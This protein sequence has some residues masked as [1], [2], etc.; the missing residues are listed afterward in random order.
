MS[1]KFN[2]SSQPD[3][4]SVSDVNIECTKSNLIDKSGQNRSRECDF[5]S[6]AGK[7][8]EDTY[9]DISLL[10]F[11]DLEVKYILVNAEKVISE[12]E[13]FSNISVLHTD[14]IPGKYEGGLKIWECS[15]DLAT[16]LVENSS[17]I[18][19]YTVLELGCGAGLPGIVAY[20]HGASVTFQDFN[21]EV[22]EYSTLPNTVLNTERS[23]LSKIAEMCSYLHGDWEDIMKKYYSD[24]T[25]AKKY[26][27]ILT[28]ETIYEK[29]NHKKLLELMKRAL[30]PDGTIYLAAK[31]HYFG[32][33]GGIADFEALINSDKTFEIVS[34]YKITEG[35]ERQILVLKFS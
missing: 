16:Y 24:V 20:L 29:S 14:L 1:F 26:D 18:K 10:K 35:V 4:E 34:V 8:L 23:N 3:T 31:I 22:L 33:G 9:E 12:N 6:V 7:K 32:V 2:F 21:P 19:G 30:M 11:A 5:L 17:I 13:A 15:I 25:T 27:V 28:S